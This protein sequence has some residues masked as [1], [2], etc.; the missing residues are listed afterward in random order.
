[1]KIKKE[2]VEKK[3]EAMDEKDLP[4]REVQMQ[5]MKAYKNIVG[6]KRFKQMLKKLKKTFPD[7][8]FDFDLE[9]GDS[10]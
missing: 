1:M 5:Q 3:I 2:L 9:E 8:D 10:K 6:N 4:S 7:K